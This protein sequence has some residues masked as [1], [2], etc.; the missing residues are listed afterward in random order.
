MPDEREALL[1]KRKVEELRTTMPSAGSEA[2]ELEAPL[3]IDAPK[4]V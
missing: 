3:N 1:N 4:E 2:L